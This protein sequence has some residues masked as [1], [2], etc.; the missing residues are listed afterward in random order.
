MERLRFWRWGRD[1]EEDD[2]EVD[3]DGPVA[4]EPV[5]TVGPLVREG[6]LVRLRR[7][8]PDNRVAFQRWYADDEIAHL[9]RH[10]QRPLNERQSRGYF[11][12]FI[13]PLSARGE[14][15]AIHER[16]DDRLI[17]TTALTD[18]VNRRGRRSAMFRIVIGE[19]E[20]WS[21][22]FGTEATI[23]V[24]AEGFGPLDLD[25]IRLEVFRHNP[26]AIRA[27][28]RV[29]FRVDGEHVEHVGRERR[30]LHVIEMVLPHAV[31]EQLHPDYAVSGPDDRRWSGRS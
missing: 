25:E 3:D 21:R 13:L 22:G 23:L 29:G 1:D 15:F 11:D 4:P 28:E 17:G 2:E 7:H 18:F 31:F 30:E 27:Y 24:M 20:R 26:R 6:R 16:E 19:K 5:R 10:D 8:V 12:T 14:C 9:L